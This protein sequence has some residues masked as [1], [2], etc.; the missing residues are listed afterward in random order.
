[1]K[2]TFL[3]LLTLVGGLAIGFLVGRSQ[4]GKAV[5][6][7]VQHS[8]V[9]MG[10]AADT[11]QAVRIL[12]YLKQGRISNALDVLELKLDHSLLTLSH[13]QELTPEM[14]DA[15]RAAREYR[16]KYPWN[17][18]APA[19]KSRIDQVLSVAK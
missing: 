11:Q 14:R 16:T 15:I 4:G 5:S 10:A 1:M 9:D 12:T 3:L 8:V 17:G 7:D 18:S 6:N 13:A 2:W 19:L